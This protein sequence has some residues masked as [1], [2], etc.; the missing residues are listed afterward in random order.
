M[1]SADIFDR[2]SIED[3]APGMATPSDSTHSAALEVD[4]PLPVLPTPQLP[5]ISATPG[6]T[7][8]LLGPQYPPLSAEVSCTYLTAI[9]GQVPSIATISHP[10]QAA[11]D[12]LHYL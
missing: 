2:V 3:T 5:K 4:A 1:T 12:S 6:H 8:P 7:S 10:H 9:T 11:M